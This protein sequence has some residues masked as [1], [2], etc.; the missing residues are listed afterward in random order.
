MKIIDV[1]QEATGF[2]AIG[3]LAV[4]VF[5]LGQM[6][7]GFVAVGQ[8]ATGVFTFGQG[9][10]GLVSVGMGGVGIY[11]TGAMLGIGGR[12][13]GGVIPLA[14]SLGPRLKLPSTTDWR[15]AADDTWVSARVTGDGPTGLDLPEGVR[16][17]ARLRRSLKAEPPGEV[18]VHVVDGASGLEVDRVVRIPR[19]RITQPRWWG[20]WVVQMALFTLLAGAWAGGVI[21]PWLYTLWTAP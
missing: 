21:A 20:I 14:P 13:F 1:G 9:A 4:G 16:V 3:Q 10:V 19:R 12:G 5:A 2:I 11:W 6:A 17:R 18:L 7:S 8:V 15:S